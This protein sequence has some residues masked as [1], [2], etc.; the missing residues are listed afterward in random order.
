MPSIEEAAEQ[1][2]QLRKEKAELERKE[3]ELRNLLTHFLTEEKQQ[4]IVLKNGYEIALQSYI[5][6]REFDVNEAQ[7]V[8]SLPIFMDLLTLDHAKF[9]QYYKKGLISEDAYRSMV[10]EEKWTHTLKVEGH[11]IVKE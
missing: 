5:R 11:V 9:N 3:K 4:R 6:D 8:L 1:L 10:T 2:Y 7:G